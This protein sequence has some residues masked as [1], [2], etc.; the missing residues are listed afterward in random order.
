LLKD[1]AVELQRPGEKV[2]VDRLVAELYPTEIGGHGFWGRLGD[3]TGISSKRWRKVFAREQRITSDML[4]ALAKLFP[5]Y[6]FWLVTGIT[7]AINGHI[8][9]EN[10]TNLSRTRV[11]GIRHNSCLLCYLH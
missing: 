10:C 8:A 7:D 11:F 1:K 4:E 9:P 3:Y 5:T 6:A 2:F